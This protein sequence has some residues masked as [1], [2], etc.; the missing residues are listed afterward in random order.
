MI[1]KF[2]P[3]LN[4]VLR[5]HHITLRSSNSP[6]HTTMLAIDWQVHELKPRLSTHFCKLYC[7]KF[8]PLSFLL[9]FHHR[10]RSCRLPAMLSS[11][12]EENLKLHLQFKINSVVLTHDYSVPL[13]TCLGTTSTYCRFDV[14]EI[15]SSGTTTHSVL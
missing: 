3:F 1:S 10:K 6:R 7:H 2:S 9:W 8:I 4:Y 13:K 12:D 11:V 5:Y 15:G 14:M